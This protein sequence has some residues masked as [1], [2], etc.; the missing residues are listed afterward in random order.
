MDV[1]EVTSIHL[2]LFYLFKEPYHLLGCMTSIP[3][4][5]HEERWIRDSNQFIRE[6]RKCIS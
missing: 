2:G 6:R 4:R 3:I 5:P 1:L